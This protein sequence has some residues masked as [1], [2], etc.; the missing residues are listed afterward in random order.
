MVNIITMKTEDV[1][2]HFGSV[3]RAAKVLNLSRLAIYKWG[4]DVPPSRQYELEVKTAGVLIS[5]YSRNQAAVPPSVR[6]RKGKQ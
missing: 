2:A 5:D 1:I 3:A 4:E 6:R